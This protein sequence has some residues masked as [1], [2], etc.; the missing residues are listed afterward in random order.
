[1]K[2]LTEDAEYQNLLKTNPAA[3]VKV[4]S[5]R[6]VTELARKRMWLNK[7]A[8]VLESYAKSVGQDARGHFRR[9][10]S[11]AEHLAHQRGDGSQLS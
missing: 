4:I 9:W 3:E 5:E 1:M 11:E 7:E 10:L 8:T 2:S 6:E